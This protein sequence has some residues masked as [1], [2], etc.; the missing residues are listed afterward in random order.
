MCPTT[1]AWLHTC[2]TPAAPP[3]PHPPTHTPPPPHT[4]TPIHPP[5]HPPTH[6]CCAAVPASRPVHQFLLWFRALVHRLAALVLAG[7]ALSYR[8]VALF[9]LAKDQSTKSAE[10]APAGGARRASTGATA[11]LRRR[12]S[13]S[14]A[15]GGCSSGSMGLL[16]SS[17]GTCCSLEARLA[18]PSTRRRHLAGPSPQTR[19]TP[20]RGGSRRPVQPSPLIPFQKQNHA[21]PPLSPSTLP[22]VPSI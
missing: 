22:G 2:P 8:L 5:T 19:S 17:A 18:G 21:P 13:C 12:S 1:C 9:A 11:A 6:P 10:L 14:S 4:Y 7:F 20:G 16:H 15:E 3:P